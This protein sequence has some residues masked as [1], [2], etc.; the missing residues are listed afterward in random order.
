[1]KLCDNGM[2]AHLTKKETLIIE[3]ETKKEVMRGN[4]NRTNGMWYLNINN[5]AASSNNINNKQLLNSVY[6]LKKEKDII[7][8]ISQA[9]WDPVPDTWIKAIKADFF[10][11]WPGLTD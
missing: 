10:A 11:T 6:E 3:E 1:M 8:Y 2:E 7:D 9:M 4:R 5:S